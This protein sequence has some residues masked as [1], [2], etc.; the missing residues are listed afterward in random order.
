VIAYLLLALGVP[1]ASVTVAARA[2]RRRIA[3]VTVCGP[4]MQP[5]LKPGDRVLIRRASFG[6]LRAGQVV[7]IEKPRRDQAV[8]SRLPRWP[9]ARRGW[10][11]KR[12]AALP[13]EPPPAAVTNAVARIAEPVVPAGKLV[14]LG[15]NPARSLDSRHFGY[16]PAERVLGVV[17][18]PLSA[19]RGRGRVP[20]AR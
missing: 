8:P 5:A 18:R 9:P 2:L 14:V 3:V 1:L 7:V 15:D 6:Q 4:S 17:I 10:M 20:P 16:I 13:G 19:Q 11:I 12:V